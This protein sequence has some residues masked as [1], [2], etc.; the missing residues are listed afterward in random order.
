MTELTCIVCPKSCRLQVDENNNFSVSG[1]GCTRG[2]RYGQEE[3]KNPTRVVTSTVKIRGAGIS[4]CPVKTTAAIPKHL[5]FIAVRLLE[6]VE[7]TA[8]VCI[9]QKVIENVCDTGVPFVVTR[10]LEKV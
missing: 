10:D 5:M 2:E 9:G 4:L 6:Q 1:Q 7:L 3:L 8:P